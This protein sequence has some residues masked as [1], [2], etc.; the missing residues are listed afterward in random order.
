METEKYKSIYKILIVSVSY[1]SILLMVSCEGFLV[2]PG[3]KSKVERASVFDDESSANLA[4]IGMYSSMLD[5]QSFASGG[6]NSISTIAGLSSDELKNVPRTDAVSLEFEENDISALNS[7]VLTLWTS[8]YRT[9]YMAN[10]G[11]EGLGNSPAIDQNVI[12]QFE[13]ECLFIRAFCHFYLVNLFGDVPLVLSTNYENNST[14]SRASSGA[15][16]DQIIADLIRAQSLM[17]DNYDGSDRTRATKGS[18]TALL[19]RTYLYLE[20]WQKA[21]IE[22]TRIIEDSRYKLT[23]LDG[24]F[25]AN[26]KETIWQ[27]RPLQVSSTNGYTNEAYFFTP[28]TINNYNAL[29]PNIISNFE[30]NDNRFSKWVGK[31]QKIYYPHKYKQ[32]SA[33]APLTEYSMVFRV[34]EQYLIRAEART[35]L[36]KFQGIGSAVSD[37]DSIRYR[38][39]LNPT[40]ATSQNDLL[41]V[42][43]NERRNEFFTEWGHRWFDLK[44]TD[45][46]TTVMSVTKPKWNSQDALY[47]LPQAERNKDRNLSPQNPGY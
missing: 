5:P 22:A 6:T 23:A 11:I 3:P 37:I 30:N 10:A 24:V 44:R 33:Q 4:L 40:T 27:L 7:T 42:I 32:N 14:I 20:D 43:E 15:V 1:I 28:P 36:G 19:A 21:E 13:G 16:Y 9:I 12:S 2:V 18:A 31:Y 8:L 17:T 38:A 29:N 46:V 39:G 35:K 26:S 45:R 47:P 25:L 41:L 34:A